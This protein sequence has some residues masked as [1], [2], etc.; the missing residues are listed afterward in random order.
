VTSGRYYA[1]WTVA[2]KQKWYAL[3][4]DVFSVAKLRGVSVSVDVGKAAMGDPIAAYRVKIEG[5]SDAEASTTKAQFGAV[6]RIL[7]T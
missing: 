5:S 7:K 3:K 2:G 1:R 4:T 6:N